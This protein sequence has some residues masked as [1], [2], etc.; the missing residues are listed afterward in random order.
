MPYPVRHAG[1][2]QH[3]GGMSRGRIHQLFHPYARIGRVLAGVP[4]T[5]GAAGA[6]VTPPARA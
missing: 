3:D 2:R 5:R 1:L 4:T 6:G